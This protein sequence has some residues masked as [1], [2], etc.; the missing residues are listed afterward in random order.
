MKYTFS[1]LLILFLF[2]GCTPSSIQLD[3]KKGLSSYTM[4]GKTGS[5]D[6]FNPVTI[7]DSISLKWEA[8][9]NGSFPNSSITGYDDFIF[10]N[11]LS[12]RVY[13][14]NADNGKT[15]GALRYNSAV[16]TT[17]IIDENNV[18]FASSED[19]ENISWLYYYNFAK[20]DLF[21]EK[22]IPG[23][24]V[25][26][27]TKAED[28]ILFNTENGKVYCYDLL[29][30]KLWEYETKTRVHSSPAVSNNVMVFGNDNGEVIGLNAEQGTILYKEKIGESFFCGA[31]VDGNT[32]YI[33]N[34]NGNLYALELST[35]K[36]RWKF[37]TGARITMI[38]VFNKTHVIIGN[39]KGELYSINKETGKLTWR[40]NT[41]GVLNASPLLTENIII[42]PDL[43]ESYHFIDVKTGEI[44]N[45][46]PMEGR[47]KLTPVIFNDVLY[48]GYDN[49]I[50]RAYEFIN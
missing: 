37:N 30:E 38:P 9:I 48:I 6:F 22:E 2:Y 29:G 21:K 39:L 33:G 31:S 32:V 28:K 49:G 42:L 18:I 8:E 35:G 15:I 7:G 19:D 36:V 46:Y 12:G 41:K 45:T 25:A 20:G 14:F 10:I 1:F 11:D 50:V 16:Y 43:N 5:R 24:V 4:F 17:P 23:R 13:C 44:K 34:D 3:T 27:L 40:T 26:E 47:G